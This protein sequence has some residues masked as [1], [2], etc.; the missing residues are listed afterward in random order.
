MPDSPRNDAEVDPKNVH[1]LLS[2]T[3][4]ILLYLYLHQIEVVSISR[5]AGICIIRLELKQILN[6]VYGSKNL[7]QISCNIACSK[8]NLF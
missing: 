3:H 1:A 8:S 2:A 5:C 6:K 4:E 7:S